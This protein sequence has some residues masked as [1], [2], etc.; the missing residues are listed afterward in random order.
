MELIPTQHRECGDRFFRPWENLPPKLFSTHP[1]ENSDPIQ[2]AEVRTSAGT[3]QKMSRP[4]SDN[5]GSASHIRSTARSENQG[6][7]IRKTEIGVGKGKEVAQIQQK[8]YGSAPFLSCFLRHVRP[9]VG[10]W[11]TTFA[12]R[13]FPFAV[14]FVYFQ[15]RV[16]VVF[17]LGVSYLDHDQADVL[18]THW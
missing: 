10:L 2:Q 7:T 4:Q 1:Q 3:S 15:M 13:P 17:Q 18:E 16:A 5:L 11:R 14:S 12:T 8:Q 6:A 9:F